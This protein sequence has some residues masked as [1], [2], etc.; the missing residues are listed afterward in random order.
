MADNVQT[1]YSQ[2]IVRAIEGGLADINPRTTV[3]G[4]IEELLGIGFGLGVIRGTA[5]DQILLPS[6]SGNT[7]RGIT[8]HSHNFETDVITDL[9]TMADEASGTVIRRGGI[10]VRPEQATTRDAQAFCRFAIGEQ[11]S[12]ITFN[13]ALTSGTIDLDVDGVAMT[14]VAFNASMGQTMSD[15]AAQLV[16]DFPTKIA[17]AATNGAGPLGVSIKCVP[18]TNI[19]VDSIVV[20]TDPATGAWANSRPYDSTVKLG[21]FRIDD[22]SV[23][24]VTG[25]AIAFSATN[26]LFD[27]AC[28][29]DSLCIARM[30]LV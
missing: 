25:T 5:G 17:S 24:T 14:Q 22:G 27:E 28:D 18:A 7:L 3:T 8:V 13:Q 11:V 4:I 21:T 19:V 15:L 9:A 30:N 16:T 23:A 10:Y 26:I 6:G 29:A 12:I 1:S 2:A 20:T